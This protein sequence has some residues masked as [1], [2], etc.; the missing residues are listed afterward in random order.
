MKVGTKNR[1]KKSL[2]KSLD[3]CQVP[4]GSVG[5]VWLGQAGFLLKSPQGKLLAIDPY[6][7]NSCKAVGASAGL[8]MDRQFPIPMEPRD[9]VGFDALVFSHSHQDH[10]D[11][12]TIQ[13]YLKAGGT[14]PF[15]APHE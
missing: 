14:G 1:S 3:A 12:E 2:R 11:P 6:L 5:L 13:P 10:V 15:I 9:L 7:S 4:R 8:N